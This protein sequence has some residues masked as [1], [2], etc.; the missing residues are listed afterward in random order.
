VNGGGGGGQCV[1]HVLVTVIVVKR[2]CS[3][4]FG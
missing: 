1:A 3:Y 2:P 4:C